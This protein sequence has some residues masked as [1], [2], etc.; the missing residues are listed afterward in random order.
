MC[1]FKYGIKTTKRTSILD[2]PKIIIVTHIHHI[3]TIAHQMTPR[4]MANS[5]TLAQ[6]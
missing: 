3:Y 5:H 4:A 1:H 2:K 6:F